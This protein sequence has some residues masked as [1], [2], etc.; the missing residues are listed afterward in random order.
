MAAIYYIANAR[1][2]LIQ[3]SP[4]HVAGTQYSIDVKLS[5]YTPTIDQDRTQFVALSGDVE[6]KLRRATEIIPVRLT[7]PDADNAQMEEFLYSVVSG[8]PFIFDAF[9]TVA[10]ADAPVN[11]I[12]VSGAISITPLQFKQA[13]YRA[14]NLTLR[15]V[16]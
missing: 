5:G 14:V 7:W 16:A 9:G 10:A 11:V 4:A 6:T 2:P 15:P 1:A 12:D 13:P 8:E 3:D